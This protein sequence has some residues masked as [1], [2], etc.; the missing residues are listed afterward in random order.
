MSKNKIVISGIN[1]FEGGPL[2]IFHD[3]LMDFSNR[4]NFY[5]ITSVGI[6]DK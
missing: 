6:N 3:T 1:I 5:L 4:N 2:T